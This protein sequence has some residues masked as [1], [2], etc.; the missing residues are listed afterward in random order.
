MT[1]PML[2]VLWRWLLTLQ[3]VSFKGGAGTLDQMK[4][5]NPLSQEFEN[6]MKHN[7]MFSRF[8]ADHVF[9]LPRNVA[10]K[11]ALAQAAQRKVREG[12]C[13]LRSVDSKAPLYSMPTAAAHGAKRVTLTSLAVTLMTLSQLL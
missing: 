5:W 6:A 8:Y 9:M 10:V 3:S 12:S 4:A 1:L 13:I 11:N 7:E 2:T